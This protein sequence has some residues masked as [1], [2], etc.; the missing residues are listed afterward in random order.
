MYPVLNAPS[1]AYYTVYH[2]KVFIPGRETSHETKLVFNVPIDKQIPTSAIT[3]IMSIPDIQT[4]A[5]CQG[6]DSKHLT[7]LIFRLI[8]NEDTKQFVNIFR[9]I[10]SN[11]YDIYYDTGTMNQYRICI[12]SKLWYSD[13][14][15]QMFINWWQNLAKLLFKTTVKLYHNDLPV[16]FINKQAYFA[17]PAIINEYASNERI[18]YTYLSQLTYDK[19]QFLH[20]S[21]TNKPKRLE[22]YKLLLK[23][24]KPIR[25]NFT[26]LKLKTQPN[27]LVSNVNRR[28]FGYGQGYGK[29]QRFHY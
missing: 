26:N 28:G 19:L 25:I 8:Q 13:E 29:G 23:H 7:F 27:V 11:G 24:K 18:Y 12:S 10:A 2:K 20:N 6:E 15:K 22:V 16:F 5:S 4:R 14:N 1:M 21:L 3:M 17:S 9:S